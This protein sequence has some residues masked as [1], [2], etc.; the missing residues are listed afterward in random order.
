[1]GGHGT[2]IADRAPGRSGPA[3]ADIGSRGRVV[4]IVLTA[5]AAALLLYGTAA[6]SDDMF[7][8][9]PFLMYAGHYPPNGV[10]TTDV[11]MART[12]DGHDV[13]VGEADTGLTRAEVAG[14]L[15]AF[16]SNPDRF[17]DLAQAFHR[18]HPLASP[19]VEMWIAQRR[20][21]LDDRAVVRH[22]TVTLVEWHAR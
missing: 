22:S 3:T 18:R 15:K 10:I 6:G 2:D 8:F 11:L 21:Q 19:Y 1:V 13:L 20:W 7:P 14:E 17:A 5:T 4:R 16:E 9:G 12:A